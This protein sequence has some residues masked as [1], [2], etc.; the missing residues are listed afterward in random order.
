[1]NALNEQRAV[2]RIL[3][4]I[5]TAKSPVVLV[6]CLAARHE[7]TAETRHLVDALNFLTFATS[8]GN[9]IINEIK[10]NFYGTITG[11]YRI[12]GSSRRWKEATALSTLDR[13]WWTVI[14]VAIQGRFYQNRWF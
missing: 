10:P 5:A 12:R 3:Q 1:M 6:D 11:K 14:L 13:S 7:A 8:M 2:E 9:S 4:G